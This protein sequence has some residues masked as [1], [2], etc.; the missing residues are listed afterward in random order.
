MIKSGFTRAQIP[1]GCIASYGNRCIGGLKIPSG[2]YFHGQKP[3][4]CQYG[5]AQSQHSAADRQDVLRGVDQQIEQESAACHEIVLQDCDICQRGQQEGEIKS[6]YPAFHV[7]KT[8]EDGVHEQAQQGMDQEPG[9]DKGQ[10]PFE[11]GIPP[12][13][14]KQIGKRHQNQRQRDTCQKQEQGQQISAC[15]H[16]APAYGQGQVEPV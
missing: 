11:V 9:R 3:G 4:A 13:K 12:G 5:R 16:P 8:E 6:P 15:H 7:P 1:I 10:D 14:G 2:V